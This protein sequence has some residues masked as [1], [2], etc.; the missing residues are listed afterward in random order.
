MN[1]F[2]LKHSTKSLILLAWFIGSNASAQVACEE[3]YKDGSHRYYFGNFEDVGRRGRIVNCRGSGFVLAFGRLDGEDYVHVRKCGED[4]CKP[5]D[6]ESFYIPTDAKQLREQN[7]PI[8]GSKFV[9]ENLYL[10]TK[11]NPEVAQN[12][13]NYL[14][15]KQTS[16]Q[17]DAK[18]RGRGAAPG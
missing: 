8:W 11:H 10:L 15:W 9:N 14:N 13:S 4:Q 7:V 1:Y 16:R 5:F 3:H 18:A 17:D 6:G 12:W 2:A